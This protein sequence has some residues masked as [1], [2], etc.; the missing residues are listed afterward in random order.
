M[1][2]N[3]QPLFDMIEEVDR[4]EW[5]NRP[6]PPHVSEEERPPFAA[7]AWAVCY[8]VMLAWG[9]YRECLLALEG[10]ERWRHPKIEPRLKLI[11][12]HP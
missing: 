9:D 2:T 10:V 12:R 6:Q 11:G 1:K 8:W 3:P 7:F 5:R 4:Q